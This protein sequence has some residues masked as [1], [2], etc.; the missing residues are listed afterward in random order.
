M[1]N[2]FIL[3]LFLNPNNSKINDH[4][5]DLKWKNRVLVVVT[6]DKEEINEITKIHNVE[7]TEREFVIIQFDGENSFIDDKLMSKRFSYSLKKKVK[8]LPEEV[9]LILIGKDGEIKNLYTKNTN[10][11]EIFTEV[12]KM[13]MRMNEMRRKINRY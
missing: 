1:L 12:D 2:S 9:H 4:L 6:K 10:L 3:L 7:L 11:N 5:K 13:P 8:D